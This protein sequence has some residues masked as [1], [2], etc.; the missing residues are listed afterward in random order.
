[1]N[2][3]ILIACREESQLT[4]HLAAELVIFGYA[5]EVD[6]HDRIARLVG[7]EDIGAILWEVAGTPAEGA[8]RGLAELRGLAYYPPVLAIG[9]GP[10][11]NQAL[12]ALKYG[13][14][15]YVDYPGEAHL[16]ENWVLQL[17]ARIE[18]VL[19]RR[20]M[21]EDASARREFGIRIGDLEIDPRRSVVRIKQRIVEMTNREM[22]LLL[23]LAERPGEVC[24]KHD[25]LETVWG[26]TDESLLTSLTTHIN[27]IRM[28][29]E[30]D[31]RNPQ[32]IVGVWGVGY[33]LVAPEWKGSREPVD[34]VL[35]RKTEA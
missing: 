31:Q 24:R 5:V 8:L 1:V 30:P 18:A 26:S 9:T 13:C 14:D 23:Q 33:K 25:L 6:R 16:L 17:E 12:I 2:R 27:R 10:D 20:Q 29:I 4:N 7:K 22:N 15:Q 35:A 11:A 21:E 19:R 34:R 3:R 28:K 32:Y